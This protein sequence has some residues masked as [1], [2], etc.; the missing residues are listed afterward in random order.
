MMKQNWKAI[1]YVKSHTRSWNMK[2]Q[3]LTTEPLHC[4][5]KGCHLKMLLSATYTLMQ[6]DNYLQYFERMSCKQQAQE[7]CKN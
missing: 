1:T 5:V 6:A 7:C 2:E 4:S 3:R